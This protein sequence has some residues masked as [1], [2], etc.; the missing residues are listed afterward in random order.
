MR[1]RKRPLP[2]EPER[3]GRKSVPGRCGDEERIRRLNAL[4]RR[5]IWGLLIFLVISLAAVQEFSFLPALSEDVRQWLGPSPPVGL[6]SAALVVY[7]FSALLLIL[8]RMWSGSDAY[9]GWSHLG[10]LSAFYG[11]YG[12]AQALDD[13]F[14]A[15]FV[16]GLTILGLE[17]YHIRSYCNEALA[18]ERE[19][20]EAPDRLDGSG[21][22]A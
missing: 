8:S 11:F 15:V 3:E 1:I 14:F 7:S 6:I 19:G 20:G 16:A 18:R 9:R 10:Y 17:Y 4:S 21:G 13:N 12:F 22:G 2:S 5:G